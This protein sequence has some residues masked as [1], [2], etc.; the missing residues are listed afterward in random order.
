MEKRAV[1]AGAVLAALGAAP[2]LAARNNAGFG[3]RYGGNESAVLGGTL[4]RPSGLVP[5]SASEMWR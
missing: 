5:V 2:Q 3:G 1:Q 4:G